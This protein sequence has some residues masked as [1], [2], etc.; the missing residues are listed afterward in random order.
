MKHAPLRNRKGQFVIEAV[1]LMVVGVGF[2]IW[3]TNQLREGKILAKLIGGPWEKVS[4]MIE[5]GVWET[6][7]KARTSH[8]NQYDRSLTIDPNG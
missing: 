1:L 3:G 6:P 4:G 8:P 5:S 2:F 7:D